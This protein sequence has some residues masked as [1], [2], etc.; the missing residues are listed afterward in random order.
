MFFRLLQIA[1]GTSSSPIPGVLPSWLLAVSIIGGPLLGYFGARYTATAPLQTALNDAFRSVMAEWQLERAQH[2]A[3]ISSVE[4]DCANLRL[5]LLERD[6]EIR[7]LKSVRDA[8]TRSLEREQ[9]HVEVP[10]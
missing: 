9:G 1:F 8:L 7:N 2:I 3:H 6:G 4:N 10:D 5:L